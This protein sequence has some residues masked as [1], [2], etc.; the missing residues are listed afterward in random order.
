MFHQLCNHI[1]MSLEVPQQ[2]SPE[3]HTGQTEIPK[4]SADERFATRLMEEYITSQEKVLTIDGRL[5]RRDKGYMDTLRSTLNEGDY[6]LVLGQL[7]YEKSNLLHKADQGES[8]AEDEARIGDVDRAI[9][10]LGHQEFPDTKIIKIDDAA[11]YL[12]IHARKLADYAR[13]KKQSGAWNLQSFSEA[14]KESEMYREMASEIGNAELNHIAISEVTRV[15]AYE[16][17]Q[18][19]RGNSAYFAGRTYAE[20]ATAGDGLEAYRNPSPETRQQIGELKKQTERELQTEAMTN[21]FRKTSEGGRQN[22]AEERERKLQ[23]LRDEILGATKPVN[24]PRSEDDRLQESRRQIEGLTIS[25]GKKSPVQLREAWPE[26]A[27]RQIGSMAIGG[28]RGSSVRG[29]ERVQEVRASQGEKDREIKPVKFDEV[30]RREVFRRF[31]EKTGNDY[32]ARTNALEI[33]TSEADI[34]NFIGDILG[35][36]ERTKQELREVQKQRPNVRAGAN[37]ASILGNNGID[38][39]MLQ[40]LLAKREGQVRGIDE[41]ITMNLKTALK[42]ATGFEISDPEYDKFFLSR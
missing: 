39:I 1:C 19:E 36:I 29:E 5:S 41:V 25:N 15:K 24:R 21:L 18:M 4:Q 8:D 35:V 38:V 28:R 33:P 30:Q 32:V 9:A 2:N 23:E 31:F 42:R 11:T 6:T 10:A 7:L 13:E 3:G 16:F 14:M 12:D 34:E 40:I 22:G 17:F 37:V 20:L 26:E 27:R